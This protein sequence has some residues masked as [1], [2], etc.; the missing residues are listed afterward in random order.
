MQKLRVSIK[1]EEFQSVNNQPRRS[2]TDGL[3]LQRRLSTNFKARSERK[4]SVVMIEKV[5]SF[6]TIFIYN[7]ACR[8]ICL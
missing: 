3:L 6:T 7:F 4:Q 5:G 2:I 8:I 1:N